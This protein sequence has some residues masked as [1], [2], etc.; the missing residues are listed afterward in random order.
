[1]KS[2]DFI[3]SDRL[4]DMDNPAVPVFGVIVGQPGHKEKPAPQGNSN[5][6]F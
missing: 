5:T 6:K 4:K 3:A 2:M 1:M